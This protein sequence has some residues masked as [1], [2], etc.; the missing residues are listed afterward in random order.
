[1]PPC[2]GMLTSNT[3]SVQSWLGRTRLTNPVLQYRFSSNPPLS[4]DGKPMVTIRSPTST[5]SEKPNR[6]GV[7]GMD[8]NR[9]MAAG[10]YQEIAEYCLRDVQATVSLYH[11][12]KERLS[13]IR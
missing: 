9:M 13:G 7:S 4:G 8:V 6:N 3:R 5:S 2:R 12:W 1:M 11:I 10:Q